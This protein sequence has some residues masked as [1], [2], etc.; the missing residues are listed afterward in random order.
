MARNLNLLKVS[1]IV[2]G[3]EYNVMALS[4]SFSF[5]VTELSGLTQVDWRNG[6]S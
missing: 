2:Q 3:H 5:R 1:A 6:V 4:L